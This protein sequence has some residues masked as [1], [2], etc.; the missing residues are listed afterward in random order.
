MSPDE[1]SQA[2]GHLEECERCAERQSK[3]MARHES[4]VDQIRTAGLP[5][6][7]AGIE[8]VPDVAG[9][10]GDAIPGYAIEEEISRGGQGIV[11]RAV[12]KSTKRIVAL[13]V[14]REGPFASRDARKRFDREIELVAGLRHP[15]IVTVFD[16]GVTADGRQYCVMDYV[17]GVSL[18]EHLRK[19]AISSVPE[20]L[21]LFVPVCEAVNH[22]HQRGVIHRDLKPSNI[23]VDAQGEPRVLDF[24]LA[25][26]LSPDREVLTTAEGVI[27]GTLPY[28]SPEQALGRHDQIDVRSDVYALGV[29]LYELLTGS[30]PYPVSGAMADALRNIAESP[31]TPPGKARRER[32]LSATSSP[33]ELQGLGDEVETI[34]LKAISKEPERRYQSAGELARDIRHYLLGEPIDAKR[35]SGWYVLRKS[36]VRHRAAVGAITAFVVLV[37]GSAIALG[38]MYA[39]Q[40]QQKE[41]AQRAEAQALRRFEQ[42]RE[43][44]GAFIN[45]LEPKIRDLVGSTPA[46]E[47]VVQKGLEYL[48]SLAADSADDLR[49]Q[50]DLASA[51]FRIGDVQGD[52]HRANLGDKEGALK[53]YMRGVRFVEAVA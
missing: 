53:S 8:L 33:H 41:L 35:D 24:G 44:A 13:K 9:P 45:E 47:F 18:N 30:Y 29:I 23:L 50:D 48:D 15:H 28:L 3:L 20:I 32:D 39:S 21:S 43:L 19:H 42:V 11:Y 12:Q 37:T 17:S 16:S 4:W 25:R 22:A 52:P 27:A 5:H 10:D 2:L 51:Y 46:R 1:E 26:P 6:P 38:L 40:K 14:L 49:L 7:V 34:I 36:L 31:P